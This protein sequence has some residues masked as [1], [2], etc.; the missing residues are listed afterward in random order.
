MLNLLQIGSIFQV[1]T[2]FSL[3]KF[4]ALGSSHSWSFPLLRSY[5]V[6]LWLPPQTPLTCISPLY[7]LALLLMLHSRPTLVFKPLIPLLPILYLLPSC[8]LPTTPC[9]WLSFYAS[10][11]S[12]PPLTPSGFFNG[13]LE[14]WIARSQEHWIGSHFLSFHPVDLISIQESNLNSSSSFRI[15]GFSAL[16]SDC[17][18]SRSGI[19][20]MS[21]MLVAVLSFSSGR[22]YL[23]SLFTWSPTLIM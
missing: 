5:L 4:R 6:T 7:N 14:V 22:A 19:L 20:V 12:S 2:T 16:H 13:M 17:T 1:L 10:A 15:P 11:S 23:L 8:P 18:H 9:S 3:S 21:P